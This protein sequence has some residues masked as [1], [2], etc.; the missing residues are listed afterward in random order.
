[1]ELE[2]KG[3]NCIVVSHK[4]EDFIVDPKLSHIGLKDQGSGAKAILL[5][6]PSFGTVGNTE[7]LVIDSPGEYEVHNCSIRGI[8]AKAYRDPEDAIK[9][10]TMYRF[11]AD[12]VTVA[13]IGNVKP[14]LGEYELEALG[15]VDVLVIPVGGYGYTLDPKEAVDVVRAI[16]PKVVIPVHYAE[17]GV[18][19]ETPQAPLEEFL[20][21]VGAHHEVLPK[22][23]LKAGTLPETLTVYELSR[24]K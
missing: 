19:Y 12:D 2:R 15:V 22:L 5:T 9:N 23:K 14:A 21:D 20:K 7:T 6:H 17:E 13:I 1:M 10:A 11:D 3:G 8:A 16:E 18:K 24:S 4:K